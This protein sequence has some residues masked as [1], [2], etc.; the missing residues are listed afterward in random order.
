M[1]VFDR[2]GGDPGQEVASP[3]RAASTQDKNDAGLGKQGLGGGYRS[4]EGYT[5][6]PFPSLGS[7]GP[8]IGGGCLLKLCH[9]PHLSR[10]QHWRARCR[11][12]FLF[13]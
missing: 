11:Q 1:G 12:A 10:D 2:E 13:F 8:G 5:N 6:A 7:A 4:M 9:L 3:R